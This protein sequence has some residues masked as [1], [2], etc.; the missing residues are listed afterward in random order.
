VHLV[1]AQ[2]W[3]LLEQQLPGLFAELAARGVPSAAVGA[4]F[5]DGDPAGEPLPWPDRESLDAAL[6]SLCRGAVSELRAARVRSMRRSAGI[7]SATMDDGE[8]VEADLLVDASGPARTTFGALASLTGRP[9]PVDQGPAG[10]GY[11]SVA[12]AEVELPA[13]RIGHRVRDEASGVRAILLE[14]RPGVWSLTLQMPPGASAPRTSEDLVTLVSRL[15]DTRLLDAIR[16]AR[17]IGPVATW[18]AQ[19]PSRCAVEELDGAPEDWLPLGDALLTT[20][21]HFGR[22]IAQ[23]AEQVE[24]LRNGLDGGSSVGEIRHELVRLTGTRWLEATMMEG[25]AALPG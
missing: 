9:V 4:T 15:D 11:A 24:V 7:W 5:L 1:P 14:T 21:P 17:F 16:L 13:G 25:L 18:A 2:T 3:R 19:P 6:L 10:G 20:P 23:L 12:L 8:T 22:G